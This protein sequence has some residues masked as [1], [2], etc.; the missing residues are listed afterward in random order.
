MEPSVAA[1]LIIVGVVFVIYV[2][3]KFFYGEPSFQYPTTLATNF[4]DMKEKREGPLTRVG[5]EGFWGGA[6]RGTG[7]SDCSRSS[8][9]GAALLSMFQG[10]SQTEEGSADYREL[11]QIVGKLSCFKKD[12]VSPS[13]IV[14]ATRYQAFA[15]AHDIEPI[16][17]TTARCFAKTMSPRDLGIAFDKWTSRGEDLVRRLCTSYG[18]DGKELDEANKYFQA[19]VR[20]VHDI[21]RGA[22]LVGEP[23][24]MGKKGPRDVG[25]HDTTD[26]STYGPYTG[27][28]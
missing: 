1:G 3:Q 17:E 8:Q 13:H 4:E 21:A 2:V 16:A 28:Y 9:E 6:A 27:Y 18:F 7:I 25:E 22:C 5:S 20:D 12:L 11:K 14:E 15:T 19:L 10:A 24:I 26:P 23:Y